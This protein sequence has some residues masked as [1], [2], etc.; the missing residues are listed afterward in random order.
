MSLK[1]SRKQKSSSLAHPHQHARLHGSGVR[2]LSRA[3]LREKLAEDA[4]RIQVPDQVDVCVVGAGAAGICA[5]VAAAEAGASVVAIDAGIECGRTILATGNGRCNFTNIEVRPAAFNCPEF[6]EQVLG[7]NPLDDILTFFGSCGMAW[8]QLEARLYPR[9]L[10]AASVR[11]VLLARSEDV[12]AILAPQRE[13]CA[14]EQKSSGGYRVTYRQLFLAGEGVA[15]TTRTIDAKSIVLAVGG[16]LAAVQSSLSE[17]ARVG[18]LSALPMSEVRPGLCAL[19]CEP[20]PFAQ[21]D[22]RRAMA[23]VSLWHEGAPV[24]RERGEVLFRSYGLSGIAVFEISRKSVAG[25]ELRVDLLPEWRAGEIAGRMFEA[26]KALRS[27]KGFLDPVLAEL[28]AQQ[29][30]DDLQAQIALA[31]DVRFCVVGP[32]DASQAQVSLGGLL[33]SSF[34]A[35]SLEA[36]EMPGLF[37]CGEALDVDGACGGYN[38]SWAWLSGLRAGASAAKCAQNRQ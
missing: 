31:K 19:A 13:V 14:I 10:S 36:K 38:L 5:G 34:D 29:A 6:V 30:G 16:A 23:A 2:P 4:R 26:P 27:L 28:V 22:G 3:Q 33:T 1:T 11:E 35:K 12:G 25:D 7:E 18:A 32:A 17:E 37:G 24:C 9:S 21:A 20:T 8:T 15:E